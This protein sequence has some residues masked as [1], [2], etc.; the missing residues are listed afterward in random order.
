[1]SDMVWLFIALI[2][3]WAGIG[4]YLLSITVRQ[5]RLEHR[6]EELDSA[7]SARLTNAQSGRSEHK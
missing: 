5:K 4:L 1:M 7:R 3:V 6:L 2:T